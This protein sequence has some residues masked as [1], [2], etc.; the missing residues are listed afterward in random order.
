MN[1]YCVIFD[2]DGVLVDTAPFHIKA[3]VKFGENHGI[4]V[5]E[6]FFWK[7]FGM[8]ND[9]LV[10]MIFK[11]EVPGE[12]VKQY[13]DEK[14]ALFR[15][16]IKGKVMPIRGLMGFVEDLVDHKITVTTGSS[17][18]RE[19]VEFIIRELGLQ[20]HMPAFVS[21]D[22]VKR[23]KPN[24]DIFI[25]AAEKCRI[26]P[27]NC[28]VVEDTLVGVKA[29]RAAGMAVVAITTTCERYEF[30]E[31]DMVIDSFNEISAGDVLKLISENKKAE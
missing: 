4:E 18:P 12:T 8:R 17:G 16:T 11:G 10:P 21:G 6:E 5:T 26:D 29:A 30:E 13:S 9:E 14:E 19:N 31:A 27:K 22:H 28:L 2:M 3:W 15:D 24:P 25:M 1:K 7:T 20:S 23:G